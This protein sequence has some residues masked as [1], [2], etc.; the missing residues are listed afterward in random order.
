MP[1]TD[2][3]WNYLHWDIVGGTKPAVNLLLN[4]DGGD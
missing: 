2:S 4:G 1:Q 3:P